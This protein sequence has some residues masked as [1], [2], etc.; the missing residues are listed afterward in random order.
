MTYKHLAGEDSFRNMDRYTARL[1]PSLIT[2]TL[3]KEPSVER[4]SLW[5]Q[6]HWSG[7]DMDSLERNL[8]NLG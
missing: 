2:S 4:T 3:H 5:V 1:N 7:N 8:S 6:N